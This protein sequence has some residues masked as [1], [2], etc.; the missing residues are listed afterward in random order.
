MAD[1]TANMIKDLRALSG[2]GMSDCK[3]ALSEVEGDMEKAGEY[4]RKKGLSQLAKKAG[5]FATEG[6][7]TAYIHS[8]SRIGVLLEINCETDFVGKT[9]DFKQFAKDVAMQIAAAS[10]I[11][12]DAAELDPAAIE[13]EREIKT[14]QAR[15]QGKMKR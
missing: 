10:P 6:V 12:V 7:V 3:K 1:I 13:K 5:R 2:A 14:A 15:E 4:L 9:D 8:N 11:V